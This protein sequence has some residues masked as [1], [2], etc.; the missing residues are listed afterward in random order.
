M[1]LWPYEDHKISGDFKNLPWN[2]LKTL[3]IAPYVADFLRSTAGQ[4]SAKPQLKYI[5]FG[6]DSED[7]G[8]FLYRIRWR[9]NRSVEKE[10]VW[11]PMLR[12]M[13]EEKIRRVSRLWPTY[14][15][16]EDER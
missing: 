1:E 12:G 15:D 8:A 13:S 4:Q 11:Y 9:R 16:Y 5:I 2:T 6:T 14:P 3:H 7:N 10:T